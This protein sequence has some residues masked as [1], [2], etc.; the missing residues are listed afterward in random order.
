MKKGINESKTVTK[1]ISCECKCTFYGRK[2]NSNQNRNNNKSQYE[3]KSLKEHQAYEKYYTWNPSTCTFKNCKYLES[4]ID[5]LVVICD[6]IIE[7][8]AKS[9]DEE[10]KTIPA[11]FNE[12]R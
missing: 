7:V 10:T 9:Y 1:N 11:N 12:K 4:I 2:C 6:E 8:V 3:F 5:D